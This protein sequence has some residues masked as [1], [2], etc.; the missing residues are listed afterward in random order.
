MFNNHQRRLLQAF[1][2]NP[3][4][5]SWNEFN[6]TNVTPVAPSRVCTTAAYMLFYTSAEFDADMF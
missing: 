6:D 1:C 5:G 2:K 4:S 3:D